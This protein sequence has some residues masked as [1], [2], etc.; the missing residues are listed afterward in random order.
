MVSRSFIMPATPSLPPG[1]QIR[2]RGGQ[3]TKVCVGTS[4]SPQSLGTG[5]ADFAMMGV[6][7][8]VSR[9][10]TCRGPEKS[11]CVKSGKMTKPILNCG[12]LAP[13]VAGHPSDSKSPGCGKCGCFHDSVVATSGK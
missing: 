12:I 8:G 3:F 6:A 2:S 1:M 5:P 9:D 10:S 11:S 4:Q 13:Y 7:D